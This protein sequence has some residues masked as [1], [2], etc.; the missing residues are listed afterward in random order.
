M[1][2]TG[3]PQQAPVVVRSKGVTQAERYLQRLCDRTF[4]SLWS[5]TNVYRG[6]RSGGGKGDGKELCDLLVVFGDDVL[7]FSDKSGAFPDTGNVHTD[8]SRWFRKAVAESACQ[9]WGAERWLKKFPDAVF[10]DAACTQPLP[11]KIPPPDRIRV[12]RI[13]VAHNVADRCSQFFP[14]SSPTLMFDSSIG[15]KDHYRDAGTYQ[16]FCIGWIDA[17]RPFVHV[18]DDASLEIILKTRDTITDLVEYLR[19]KEAL[20]ESARSRKVVLRYCGEE[21]L[22]ANYLPR[23]GRPAGFSLPNDIDYFFLEEGDWKAFESS[24]ERASQLAADSGSYLWD[25]VIEQ[26]NANIL[27]GTSYN[28]QGPDHREPRPIAD[29][30]KTLRFMARE[31]RVRRRFLSEILLD[32]V[33]TTTSS[34]WAR[35]VVLPSKPGDAHYCFLAF[36]HS[37]SH[38]LEEYR[39]VRTRLLEALCHVTKLICPEAV[40]IVGFAT[41]PGLETS[42]RS[43][44]VAY[45]DARQWSEEQNEYARQL[46]IQYGLLV[47]PKMSRSKTLEIPTPPALEPM[48]LGS[49]PRNKPCPCGSGQKYK[50]CH[51]R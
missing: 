5:Y 30:E 19:W 8:W 38:S 40:D 37:A 32:L 14:G 11:L 44:D 45:L 27:G 4:L 46:Q 18:F 20:I 48:R 34:Q 33:R 31:K 15:G 29:R 12:H 21:D 23:G 10:L 39:L 47:K 42:P 35:R 24:P 50:K 26:F 9:A 25:A 1:D 36:P 51:G 16:P 43:E 13:V 22:L 3:L 2:P 28:P 49:N 41:Q 6:Q 7:I 17:D